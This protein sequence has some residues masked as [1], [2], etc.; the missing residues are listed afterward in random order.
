MNPCLSICREGC[1]FRGTLFYDGRCALCIITA[2]L[3][4]PSLGRRGFVLF[5]LQAAWVASYLNL[6]SSEL[7]EAMRLV[8]P[9]EKM[10][11]G[12]DAVLQL[13]SCF[14]WGRPLTWL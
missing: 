7:R 1:P 8:T 5:P 14:W 10:F 9:D 6:P 12:A 4:G 11:S 3:F 13:V 2:R